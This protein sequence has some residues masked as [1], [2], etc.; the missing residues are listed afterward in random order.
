MA[1]SSLTRRRYAVSLSVVV[2]F[3]TGGAG[4]TKLHETAARLCLL[5]RVLSVA[6]YAVAIVVVAFALFHPTLSVDGDTL[7]F[8]V[9][10]GLPAAL[11][12]LFYAQLDS[13]LN[14]LVR[15]NKRHA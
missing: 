15:E 14:A 1:E 12:G 4:A 3:T 2:F 7:T 11:C 13:T 9:F 6:A 5:V 8:I 10:V